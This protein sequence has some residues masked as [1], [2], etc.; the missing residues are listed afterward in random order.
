MS[1]GSVLGPLLFKIFS[2]YIEYI[3]IQKYFV[4]AQIYH[5]YS[6]NDMSLAELNSEQEQFSN[7]MNLIK[8]L[9]TLVSQ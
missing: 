3:T 4:D 1:Q 2:R 7:E 5:S 8:F 6:F 9:N